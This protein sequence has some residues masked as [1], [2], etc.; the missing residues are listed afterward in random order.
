[1]RVLYNAW[2]LVRQPNSPEALHLLH[3]FACELPGIEQVAALPGEPAFPL[4][5]QVELVVEAGLDSPRERLVW[6]QSRLLR[7]ARRAGAD[8]IHVVGDTPPLWGRLP[9]LFSPTRPDWGQTPATRRDDEGRPS[10]GWVERIRSAMGEGGLARARAGLWPN[11][12]PAPAGIHSMAQL[13]PAVHPAFTPGAGGSAFASDNMSEAPVIYHSDGTSAGLQD[14]LAA[15]TWAA[16]PVGQSSP[17]LLV[18][19]SLREQ[20][21]A[22]VLSEQMGIPQDTVHALPPLAVEDLASLY[23]NS[24]AVLHPQAVAPWDGPAR[25]ALSSGVPLV[26]YENRFSDAL[27]G[28]GAYLVPETLPAAERRRRLGAALITVVVEEQVGE[29][30]R[31]AAR[32]KAASWEDS[33]SLRL[34]ELYRQLVK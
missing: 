32:E 13:P 17:L 21:A 30:L 2:P 5:P 3:L 4:P 18:G 6:E 11:D 15:W 29:R 19:L 20:G 31:R 8:V 34:A 24:A 10:G 27:A 1:M 33:F 22:G 7:L 9:V 16:A 25:L 12:L 28:Q 23:Q 14:A 26:A